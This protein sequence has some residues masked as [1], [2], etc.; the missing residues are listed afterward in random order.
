[1]NKIIELAK[2]KE[3]TTKVT[4]A[5]IALVDIEIAICNEI[6]KENEKVKDEAKSN[7]EDDESDSKSFREDEE[8]GEPPEQNKYL[9]LDEVDDDKKPVS[10]NLKFIEHKALT[11]LSTPLSTPRSTKSEEEKDELDEI[12]LDFNQNKENMNRSNFEGIKD[13]IKTFFKKDFNSKNNGF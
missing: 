7:E 12:N 11:P 10:L 13:K 2:E 3:K 4:P 8:K 5:E 1:M 9:N 6:I